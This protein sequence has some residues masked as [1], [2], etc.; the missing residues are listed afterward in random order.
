M[1]VNLTAMTADTQRTFAAQGSRAERRRARVRTEMTVA[2]RALIAEKGVAGLR[3][4]DVTERADL[5]FGSFYTY[6]DSK[7][8]V[9]EA[10]IADTIG[11]L[12]DAL[13][14]LPSSLEDPAERVSV[15]CRGIVRL[16]YQDRELARLLVNLERAEARLEEM[17]GGQAR[18]VMVAGID[19]GR[20]TVDDLPSFLVFAISGCFAVMR[21]IL[22]GRLG[23]GADITCATA[24][25]AGAGL[26][27]AEA[28][29]IARRPLPRFDLPFAG[30]SPGN[31]SDVPSG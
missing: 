23:D 24:I 10:V 18:T 27:Y 7:A 3:V 28:A 1:E 17:V 30:R 13:I 19:A 20:F 25:L 16:A 11:A 21:G 8:E 31:R 6:F 2:A 4:S 29:E 5:A 9:I 12:A 22:E 15:A 14:S 26:G